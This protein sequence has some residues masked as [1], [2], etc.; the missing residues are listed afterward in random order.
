[1]LRASALGNFST[2]VSRQY[3]NSI[4]NTILV[5]IKLK[6]SKFNATIYVKTPV[7]PIILGKFFPKR[8]SLFKFTFSFIILTFF[9]IF[10]GWKIWKE[11]STKDAFNNSLT[12]PSF[13]QP[14][15]LCLV[16]KK[17]NHTISKRSIYS[18]RRI[19]KSSNRACSFLRVGHC[20]GWYFSIC[21][22]IRNI[23]IKSPDQREPEND[24]ISSLRSSVTLKRPADESLRHSISSPFPLLQRIDQSSPYSW[25]CNES[26]A[27]LINGFVS[28]VSLW[29][30][31]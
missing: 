13:S 1:M 24:D 9:Y 22:N 16:N 10:F 3:R 20:L 18:P 7:E 8:T 6:Y 12:Y 25:V 21:Q 28:S 27:N 2:L 5:W 17:K 19:R 31:I 11:S 26:S 23:W 14:G 30:S 15:S 4:F 29:D